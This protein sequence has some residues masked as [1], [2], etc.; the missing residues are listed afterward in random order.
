[1]KSCFLPS[2]LPHHQTPFRTHDKRR[3]VKLTEI[4]ADSLSPAPGARVVETLDRP[5]GVTAMLAM[6]VRLFLI[7]VVVLT[8]ATVAFL[9][10]TA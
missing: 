10:A 6:S 1:M 4:A 2:P 7:A 9:I 5:E 8:I 3:Y